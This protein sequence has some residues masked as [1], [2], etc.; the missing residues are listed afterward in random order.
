MM[1]MMMKT[2]MN[3]WLRLTKKGEV[4]DFSVFWVMIQ[5]LCCGYSY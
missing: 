5:W 4:G 2:L 1:D 3:M